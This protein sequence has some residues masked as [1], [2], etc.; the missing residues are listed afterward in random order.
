MRAQSVLSLIGF[1]SLAAATFNPGQ[2][3]NCTSPVYQHYELGVFQ[4]TCASDG[5]PEPIK[6]YTSNGL[7]W[8]D[9][10]AAISILF[11]LN[12]FTLGTSKLAKPPR[13]LFKSEAISAWAVIL[14]MTWMVL[15][16]ELSFL[17]P[18]T[19]FIRVSR[20]R[21]LASGTHST[22]IMASLTRNIFS[23]REKLEGDAIDHEVLYRQSFSNYFWALLMILELFFLL[24]TGLAMKFDISAA[25]FLEIY[26]AL[27]TMCLCLAQGFSRV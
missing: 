11:L 10:Y 27:V 16:P 25:T 24:P 9:S 13:H 18:M 26:V 15:V 23:P 6:K 21:N 22:C 4:Q 3:S 7:E 2:L 19:T 17:E 14:W 1:T 8:G 20:A 12:F 5:A